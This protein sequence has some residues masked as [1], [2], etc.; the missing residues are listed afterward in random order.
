[1]AINAPIVLL[2]LLLAGCL[3]EAA[4]VV[5]KD[6]LKKYPALARL[7][8]KLGGAIDQDTMQALEAAAGSSGARE[9]ARKFLKDRR[10]I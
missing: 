3:A 9:A 7:I 4:P 8:N 5:R 1:M 10:F 6:T 2:S